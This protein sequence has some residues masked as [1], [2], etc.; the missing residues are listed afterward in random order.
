MF[1]CVQ[2]STASARQAVSGQWVRRHCCAVA[3]L[4]AAIR[5]FAPDAAGL[6][7]QISGKIE[8]TDSVM[9]KHP[10]RRATVELW[11]MTPTGSVAVES[12]MTSLTGT[13]SLGG[14]S[15]G[16]GDP[17]WIRAVARNPGGFVNSDGTAATLPYHRETVVM[18]FV[19]MPLMVD[20]AI[21]NGL[22]S[23][24]T[25]SVADAVYTGWHF[26]NIVSAA[27]PPALPVHFPGAFTQYLPPDLPT[28]P[29]GW[30][31]L[32][33]GDKWDWDPIIHEYGHLLSRRDMLANYPFLGLNHSFG[34]SN[35]PTQGK[36]NGVRL[37]WQEGLADYLGI[38]AQAVD[39]VGQNLPITMPFV[40]DHFYTDTIDQQLHVSL[41]GDF[42]S[43]GGSAVTNLFPAG[44]GDE[45][46]IMR[47][48]WDLADN[49]VGDDDPI[50][51]GHGNFYQAL[52]ALVDLDR[53]DDVWD[54]YF[55]SSGDLSRT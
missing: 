48:L 1:T 3:L 38:A 33:D 50:G 2:P 19:P 26:A 10:A 5:S 55:A 23:E 17:F 24:Q 45:L 6:M 20:L 8:W 51:I 22:T 49:E 53:L 43:S 39:R 25:F 7:A 27:A 18:A 34:S 16:V 42:A 4:L 41:E 37:A 44:E 46:S 29:E 52:D 47:I 15:L 14:G 54:H 13:Y 12:T 21:G 28:R 32:V 30:I 31:E 35:I 36:L 9:Q 11:T 40:G